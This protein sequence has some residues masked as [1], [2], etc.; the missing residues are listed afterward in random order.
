MGALLYAGAITFTGCSSP[1]HNVEEAEANVADANKDLVKANE[2]YLAD[3]ENSRRETA[4]RVLANEKSVF[5][6]NERVEN[7]KQA[8]TMEYKE[9]VAR[10]EQKNSDMKKK[11]DD[12]KAEG[13]ENWEAFK[14]QFNHDMEELGQSFQDLTTRKTK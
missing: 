5:E 4:E 6:F 7:K 9:K 3:I 11:M 14:T 13:K 10:L 1:A 12:Y 8:A 2:E